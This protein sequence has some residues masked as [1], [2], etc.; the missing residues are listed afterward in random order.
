MLGEDLRVLDDY[1]EHTACAADEL[2][3]DAEFFFERGRQT[4]GAWQVV[5]DDAVF[6]DDVHRELPQTVFT[7]TAV[8]LS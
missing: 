7:R 3:I 1:V 5:S 2:R 8:T 6:D 4:G